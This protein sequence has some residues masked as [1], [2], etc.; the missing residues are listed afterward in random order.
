[1]GESYPRQRERDEEG[2]ESEAATLPPQDFD[3]DHKEKQKK[4]VLLKTITCQCDVLSVGSSCVYPCCSVCKSKVEGFTVGGCVYDGNSSD[5]GLVRR[6]MLMKKQEGNR[7]NDKEERVKALCKFGCA[8]G[9]LEVRYRLVLTLGDDSQTRKVVLFGKTAETL[10]GLSAMQFERFVYEGIVSNPDLSQARG[11]S[12]DEIMEMGLKRCLVGQTLYVDF[13]SSS[14][15]SP[16]EAVKNN[17]SLCIEKIPL[18]KRLCFL[19]E[20]ASAGGC[21]VACGI[22]PVHIAHFESVKEFLMRFYFPHLASCSSSEEEGE[23]E[24]QENGESYKDCFER[25]PTEEL[26]HNNNEDNN[27][28]IGETPLLSAQDVALTAESEVVHGR[29]RDSLPETPHTWSGLCGSGVVVPSSSLSRQMSSKWSCGD[30]TPLKIMDLGSDM[31]RQTASGGGSG[32]KQSSTKSSGKQKKGRGNTSGCGA[33]MVDKDFELTDDIEDGYSLSELEEDEISEVDTMV[34][35][36]VEELTSSETCDA[37]L[38][39][40]AAN[41]RVANP[42]ASESPKQLN[43]N[44]TD[45]CDSDATWYDEADGESAVPLELE[46]DATDGKVMNCQETVFVSSRREEDKENE[47]DDVVQ[48]ESLRLS[49]PDDCESTEVLKANEGD[50]SSYNE[51]VIVSSVGKST[52][53]FSKIKRSEGAYMAT[54]MKRLELRDPNPKN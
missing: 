37:S 14:F 48:E 45:E 6:V 4:T 49:Q 31:L 53:I 34:P 35:V 12:V 51:D 20:V 13:Q 27:V 15:R 1:M 40:E 7:I 9:L 38:Y 47:V 23:E 10:F 39:E 11:E 21:I 26:M 28:E 25:A 33:H 43:F 22:R 16:G 42:A 29:D 8:G 19:K 50:K 2:E 3:E 17:D 32:E 46:C 44:A 30:I 52:P 54:L 24:E 5:N 18:R 36:D 41:E